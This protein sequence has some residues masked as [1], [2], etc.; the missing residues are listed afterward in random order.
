M[1]IKDL[2]VIEQT[3]FSLLMLPDCSDFILF[4]SW[5]YSL[6]Y[7][8]RGMKKKLNIKIFFTFL[9]LRFIMYISGAR[10]LL[11]WAIDGGDELWLVVFIG[12]WTWKTESVIAVSIWNHIHAFGNSL[13]PYIIQHIDLLSAELEWLLLVNL[14][15][16]WWVEGTKNWNGITWIL[17]L[18]LKHGFTFNKD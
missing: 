3:F 2:L 18:P 5:S 13:P 7:N 14:F 6:G 10:D 9:F 4:G 8:V 12:L 16:S 15:L 17:M 1:F 11:H